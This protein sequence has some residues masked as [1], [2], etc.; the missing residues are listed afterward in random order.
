[1]TPTNLLRLVSLLQQLVVGRAE[2]AAFQVD[3]YAVAA[4]LVAADH[5]AVQVEHEEAVLRVARM[6]LPSTRTPETAPT[7]VRC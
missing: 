2:L 3:P 7:S 6:M 4:S 1:M 5:R